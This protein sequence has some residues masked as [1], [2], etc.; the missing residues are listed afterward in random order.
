MLTL[1]R[2]HYKTGLIIVFFFKFDTAT[3]AICL[4][5]SNFDPESAVNVI[6]YGFGDNER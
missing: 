5:N 4:P 2:F 6:D 1:S 3:S